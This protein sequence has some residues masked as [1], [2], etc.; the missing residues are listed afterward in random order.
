MIAER[1]HEPER[2]A[3]RRRSAPPTTRSNDAL[4]GPLRA[5]EDR[6]PQL[7]ERH[8]LARHV[9]AALDQQLGRPRRDAHLHAAAVRSLDDLEQP[10][11]RGARSRRRSA[12]RAACRRSEL[13]DL[14]PGLDLADE[15]V[16]DAATA[17]AERLAKV[18]RALRVADE[19]G[20]AAHTGRAQQDVP[21]SR[22][23]ARAKEGDQRARR[24]SRR[25][26]RGRRS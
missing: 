23:V 13:L 14:G 9:L 2:Q 18:R 1:D 24:G 11:R 10:R 26:R 12:R 25:R 8:A 20:V 6:R 15:L 5:G 17:R 7:E 22:L 4:H 21:V 16:V 3:E 19:H